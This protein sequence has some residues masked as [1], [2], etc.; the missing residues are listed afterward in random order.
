MQRPNGVLRARDITVWNPV[1]VLVQNTGTLAVPAGVV[2][3]DGDIVAYG[4]SGSAG[5]GVRALPAPVEL[6]INGAISGENGLLTGVAV[7]DA[8]TKDVDFTPALFTATSSINGCL[9]SAATCVTP[10]PPAP[11][12]DSPRPD[13]SFN[14]G[15]NIPDKLLPSSD[16]DDGNGGEG[17][18]SPIATPEKLVDAQAL[19]KDQ[20]IDEPVAG[21]GNPAMMGGD[22]GEEEEPCRG[23]TAKPAEASAC[24]AKDR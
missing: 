16:D 10:R 8:V 2:A 9:L 23:S 6:I 7:W 24:Q 20:I 3:S 13:V 14:S 22:T 4:S 11:P 1:A 17:D 15:P 18:K 21:S 5:T 19:D 12:T